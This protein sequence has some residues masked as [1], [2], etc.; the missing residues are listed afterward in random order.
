MRVQKGHPLLITYPQ[1]KS[2]Q[3]FYANSTALVVKYSHTKVK[4]NVPS[5][6]LLVANIDGQE[7]VV[8]IVLPVLCYV[9]YQKRKKTAKPNCWI[10][11]VLRRPEE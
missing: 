8:F 10:R 4:H 11:P 2:A 7:E 9:L 6:I 1:A 5:V 3:L